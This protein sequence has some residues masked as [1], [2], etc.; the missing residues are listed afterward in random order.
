MS[1]PPF[2]DPNALYFVGDPHGRFDSLHRVVRDHEPKGVI[3]LGDFDLTEPLHEAVG[4]AADHIEFW[5]IPGNHDFASDAAYDL[6]FGST[7]AGRN[8]HGRVTEIAG[9]RVAGL[10]GH[11]QGAIWHP[12]VNRG[13]P[14]YPRRSDFQAVMG[15]GNRWRGG[16]PRKRRGAIWW[17]DYTYLCGQRADVLVSHEAPSCHPR[18]FVEIDRLAAAIGASLIVH[19]HHHQTYTSR[20]G[21]LTVHGVGRAEVMN[22]DGQLV[23]QTN[24]QQGDRHADD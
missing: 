20:C 3:L 19:G 2:R 12:A 11:F 5:W 8:L 24:Q 6:L 17:E 13:E 21:D 7:L 14:I 9:L 4:S 23:S 18:G 15:N 10:G 22:L 16:L 1:I